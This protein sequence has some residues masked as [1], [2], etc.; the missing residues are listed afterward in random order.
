[1]ANRWT[2]Q[3][4]AALNKGMVS[5]YAKVAIGASGAATLS[6]ANSK[7]IVSVTRNSAGTYTFVFGTN[8]AALDTYYAFCMCRALFINNSTS[9]PAAPIMH[10]ITDSSATAGTASIKVQFSAA[11]AGAAVDPDNGSTMLLR[12]DFQNSSAY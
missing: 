5:I 10:V 11:A 12:F 2:N 6:T 8:S 7:G 1:M 3:Y 4:S 9:A